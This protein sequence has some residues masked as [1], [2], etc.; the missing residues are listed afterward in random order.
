[1]WV[2]CSLIALALAAPVAAD[3][4]EEQVVVDLAV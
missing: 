4:A 3:E 2:A 1:M